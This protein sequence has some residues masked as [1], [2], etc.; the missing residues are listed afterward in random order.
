MSQ[1][2][3]K[4]LD[5]RGYNSAETRAKKVRAGRAGKGPSAV[6]RKRKSLRDPKLQERIDAV[7]KAALAAE[8]VKAIPGN[9]DVVRHIRGRLMMND[10]V[11]GSR[12]G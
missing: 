2:V 3:T 12:V 4:K 5:Q 1:P 9:N 6:V 11:R 8:N 7:V 10:R